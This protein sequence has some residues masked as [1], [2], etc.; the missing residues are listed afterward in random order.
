MSLGIVVNG[1]EG[2]VLAAES[3]G[4]LTSTLPPGVSGS[5]IHV[6]FDNATKILSFKEPH[7]YILY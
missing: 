7:D 3:R 6:N 2:L 5:P 4:T 1:P